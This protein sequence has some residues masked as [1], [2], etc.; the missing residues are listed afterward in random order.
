MILLQMVRNVR[1]AVASMF[2]LLAVSF[3]QSGTSGRTEPSITNTSK[4]P[5]QVEITT[6]IGEYSPFMSVY[7]AGMP[8]NAIVKGSKDAA[9]LRYHWQAED[10]ALFLQQAHKSKI[11]N[12]GKNALTGSSTVGWRPVFK[13]PPQN[14]YTVKISLEVLDKKKNVIGKAEIVLYIDQNLTVTAKT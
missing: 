5:L 9:K 7:P 8:L 6:G 3:A 12:K 4:E 1:T 11:I 10:G 14:P 2:F 13:E